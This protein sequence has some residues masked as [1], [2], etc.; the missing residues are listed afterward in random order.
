MYGFYVLFKLS[1]NNGMMISSLVQIGYLRGKEGAN[2][3]YANDK[4]LIH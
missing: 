2:S 3:V 1:L 4:E